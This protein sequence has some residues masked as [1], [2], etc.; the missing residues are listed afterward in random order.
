[1]IAVRR[2][3]FVGRSSEL[4]LFRGALRSPPP[5]VLLHVH[6]PGGVGK[7]ELLHAFIE[8]AERSGATALLVDGRHIEPSPSAFLDALL[9]AAGLPGGSCW[10]DAVRPV[11]GG[12][13]VLLVD[14]YE[15]LSP[16]DDWMRER[17]LPELPEGVL[18]VFA[19]RHR[20][21]SRW[22]SD[23]GWVELVREARL[24]NLEPE[25][26]KTF[27]RR[28]GVPEMRHEGILRFA[29]G[30]P[31]A[32]V[33][34]AQVT[35]DE[36]VGAAVPVNGDI[37][38]LLVQRFVDALP[39]PAHRAAL[40]A[41]AVA[42]VT[43]EATL[44]AALGVGDVH[45]LFTW[46]RGLPFIES[47]ASGL[48]PHDLTRDVLLADLEWR[49]PG[50]GEE[51]RTRLRAQV[52][53][54]VRAAVGREQERALYDFFFLLGDL[55]ADFWRWQAV[56]E[57]F[58]EGVGPGDREAI[59]A[60]VERHEGP[61]SAMVAAMWLD[62]QPEAF[63]VIR[64]RGGAEGVLSWL[65]LG[66]APPDAVAAD[67]I[68]AAAVSYARSRAAG[69]EGGVTML[70]FLVHRDVYQDASVAVN[71][72]SLLHVRQVLRP[73]VGWD[74]LVVAEGDRWRPLFED[75]IGYTR[76]PEVDA[77][78]G[79]RSYCAFAHDWRREPDAW[80]GL[81]GDRDQSCVG[82]AVGPRWQREVFEKAVKDALRDLGRLDRLARNPLRH[83]AVGRQRGG[84]EPSAEV[85]R[86]LLHEA[87]DL[88]RGHPRDEKL[89]RAIDRTYL[90][91]AGTQ[92]RAAEV[93]DLPFSTYRGHLAQ[94]VARITDWL[95]D[96]E[97]AALDERR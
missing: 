70:R 90:R 73:N 3:R 7:T 4:D 44:R 24:E 47:G 69:P 10:G 61:E 56:G 71:H 26:A 8:L 2:A 14:T 92:E 60:M 11:G 77:Q 58:A 63:T 37:V 83:S 91:P 94:G 46:L 93:L 97:A 66:S 76:V 5:F 16:L 72:A 40:E 1:M 79:S 18:V 22:R 9:A 50:R 42:R 48:W 65:D 17:F 6:G 96:Q 41:C 21:S 15:M 68:A 75:L 78:V 57:T 54:R 30:H 62:V 52:S 67:P 27:L 31:L 19:G 20:L 86:E 85:V 45:D 43:T 29:R 36:D 82:L 32:L 80:V 59:V 35:V 33:L 95:W 49:D 13:C 34:L 39:T 23:M 74:F 87:A 55:T 51:L 88:L 89:F 64:G 84:E 12:R 53:G 81:L 28:V 25:D 38:G